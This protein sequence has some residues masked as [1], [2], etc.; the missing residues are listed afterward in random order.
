MRLLY[1]AAVKFAIQGTMSLQESIAF[2]PAL[3]A[4]LRSLISKIQPDLLILD[5]I[6]LGQFF[7]DP[8]SDGLRTVLYMDD[9]F[10]VRYR[11]ML[12]ALDRYPDIT[13]R[14][15]GTLRHLLPEFAG[16]LLWPRWLQ[17]ALFRREARLLEHIEPR[18]ALEFPT[19]L[20]PE[21]R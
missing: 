2:S 16:R 17:S 1:N 7:R 20:L 8:L 3:Q 21:Q 15:V 18:Y 12:A 4:R 9:L 11:N 19:C 14:P 13:I 5:T 6:R 10:N